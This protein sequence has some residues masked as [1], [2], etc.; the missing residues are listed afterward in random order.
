MQTRSKSQSRANNSVSEKKNTV[1]AATV[2]ATVAVAAS[3]KST[4]TSEPTRYRTR[5]SVNASPVKEVPLWESNWDAP[6][7]NNNNEQIYMLRP[8]YT[9][10]INFDEA[11]TAWRAN[12][13]R[14]GACYKYVCGKTSAAGKPCQ[15]KPVQNCD[16]CHQHV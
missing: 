6:K 5:N 15:R 11:S 3:A 13:A 7:T 16:N 14:V 8:R 1:V 9:V 10:D 12:K 4:A 2:A